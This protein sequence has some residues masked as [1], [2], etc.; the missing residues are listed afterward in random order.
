MSLRKRSTKEDKGRTGSG[1][2]LFAWK[3]LPNKKPT[4]KKSQTPLPLG[5]SHHG[6]RRREGERPAGESGGGK[7]KEEDH[8]G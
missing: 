4:T 6:R 2:L 1:R 7:L 8:T 3:D 5:A